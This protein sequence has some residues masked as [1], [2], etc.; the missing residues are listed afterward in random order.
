MKSRYSLISG[1][2]GRILLLRAG[3]RGLVDLLVDVGEGL[4]AVVLG[5]HLL[6][7]GEVEHGLELVL[8]HVRVGVHH[9]ESGTRKKR[10]KKE[11]KT[12]CA[13][14]GQVKCQ[15]TLHFS[16]LTAMLI[17]YAEWTLDRDL[18]M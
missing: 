3:P 12:H 11:E 17:E 2:C 9:L 6:V 1:W 5:P 13:I 14:E 7:E 18:L 8:R 4:L 10:I 16:A 15:P